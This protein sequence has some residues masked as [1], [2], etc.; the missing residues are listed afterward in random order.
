MRKFLFTLSAILG[1]G[2]SV[3]LAQTSAD[4]AAIRKTALNYVEGWYEGDAVRMESAL[5]PELA[6]R[7]VLVDEKTGKNWLDA[8]GASKLVSGTRRGGGKNTPKDQQ[9]KDVYILDIFGNAA[10]VKAIMSGWIDYMHLAKWNGEW[11]IV[12]VLWEYK[13]KK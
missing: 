13:P 10:S 3:L 2:P 6:K 9:Q 7:I 12:N 11:K 1:V 8:M 4:S 5:H